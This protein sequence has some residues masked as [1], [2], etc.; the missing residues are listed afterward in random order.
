MHPRL[1][2]LA[3]GTLASAGLAWLGY[4]LLRRP[5][6]V[7]GAL[8][9]AIGPLA[10]LLSVYAA[11]RGLDRL[12]TRLD[13]ADRVAPGRADWDDGRPVYR[14]RLPLTGLWIEVRQR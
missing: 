1:V 6:L 3:A 9:L 4:G 10:V 11:A 13:G 12:L 2:R 14:V 8:V 5:V 7:G